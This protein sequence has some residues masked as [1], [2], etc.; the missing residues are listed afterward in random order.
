MTVSDEMLAAAIGCAAANGS[1]NSFET[2]KVKLQLRDAARPIYRK[3]T[4]LGVV[5]QVVREDGFARGLMTPGISASLVR[6][7][8]Y[9]AFRVGLYPR[10]C[11]APAAATRVPS[12]P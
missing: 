4:M 12:H 9:G 8:A 6:S 3:P 5:R 11:P 10:C 2:T 7:L 1:L